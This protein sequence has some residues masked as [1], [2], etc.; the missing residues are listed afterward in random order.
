VEAYVND[1][2]VKSRK[3][4]DHASDL[5][6][7]FDNLRAASMKLNPE[8]CVFGVRTGKLLGFLVF[9]RGIEANPEKIDAI[10]QMKPRAYAKYKSSL[11]E[12]RR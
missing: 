6:E 10:Q 3:S 11:A 4:F 2:V 12:L 7:T 8:K 9:E 5:Q 1:I